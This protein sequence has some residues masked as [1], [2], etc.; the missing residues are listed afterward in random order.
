MSCALRR[1]GKANALIRAAAPAS[2]KKK[3]KSKKEGAES[4]GPAD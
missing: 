2:K 1:A 4:D 3:N